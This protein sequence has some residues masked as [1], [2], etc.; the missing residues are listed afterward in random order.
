M[1]QKLAACIHFCIGFAGF[2]A[3]YFSDFTMI[4]II[5]IKYE[6]TEQF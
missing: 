5:I 1:Q 2:H 4:M 6:Y 3:D